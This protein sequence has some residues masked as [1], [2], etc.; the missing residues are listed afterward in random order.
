M[1]VCSNKITK[2][3]NKIYNF[4]ESQHNFYWVI[5]RVLNAEK[6]IFNLFEHLLNLCKLDVALF[7]VHSHKL[8]L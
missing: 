3:S 8:L 1:N 6:F 4:K 7:S 2:N 5:L